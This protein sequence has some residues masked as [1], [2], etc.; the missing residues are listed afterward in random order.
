M[1]VDQ[2][3]IVIGTAQESRTKE[4]PLTAEER[5]DLIDKALKAEKISHYQLYALKDIHD[6]Q[7]YV[8][9]VE[10]HLPPFDVVFTGD[11]K[12]NRK[13]FLTAG[14]KVVTSPRLG[15]W[16]ATEVRKRIR[17]KEGYAVFVPAKVKET[18][19][20]EKLIKIIKET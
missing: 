4:N 10:K 2:L 11:N 15:G 16:M 14:Y 1:A 17:G 7:K 3:F 13:L 5:Q 19:E 18:L 20:T 8:Q 9:Y 6:D 12:L